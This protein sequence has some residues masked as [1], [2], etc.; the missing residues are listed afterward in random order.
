MIRIVENEDEAMPRHVFRHDTDRIFTCR[1]CGY[2]MHF[3]TERCSD[4]WEKAPFYN[5]REFWQL[6]SVLA[7]TV[8]AAAATTFVLLVL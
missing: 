8:A 6:L 3:G 2:L 1:N 4:C 7:A 5:Q